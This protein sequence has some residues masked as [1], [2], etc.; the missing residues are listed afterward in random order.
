M[1][2]IIQDKN[3]EGLAPYTMSV[4]QLLAKP[5]P[6]SVFDGWVNNKM[7]DLEARFVC[8][9]CSKK[10]SHHPGAGYLQVDANFAYKLYLASMKELAGGGKRY[11]ERED[12]E[13]KE[14]SSEK[15]YQKA[16]WQAVH[17]ACDQEP[18]FHYYL[19][20]EDN[21]TLGRVMDSIRHV[22]E[23]NWCEFTDLQ[24][25]VARQLNIRPVTL[26]GKD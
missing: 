7:G 1:T 5:E 8:D 9:V 21:K 6:R 3:D 18:D 10:I 12:G 14:I 26:W 16:K 23:K 20:S 22:S 4:D 24:Q 25:F 19:R 2:D 11:R 17:I 13:W 15:L